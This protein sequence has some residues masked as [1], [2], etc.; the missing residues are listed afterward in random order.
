MQ[1]YKF[2]NQKKKKKVFLKIL[3]KIK[4]YQITGIQKYKLQKYK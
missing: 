3:K 4:E 1:V 2:K